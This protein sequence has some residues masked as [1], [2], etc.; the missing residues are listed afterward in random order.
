MKK[1]TFKKTIMFILLASLYFSLAQKVMADQQDKE[2]AVTA[3]NEVIK[4]DPNNAELWLHLGFAYRKINKIS[5]AQ[6]AFEKT[7]ELN[8]ENQEALF[9]L[10]LIYEK[11]KQTQKALKAWKQYLS[12]STDPEKRSLAEK[13]IHHLSQ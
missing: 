9:M 8:P 12:V 5:Q 3:L 13:H 7:A 6:Q 11:N 2:R 4:K 1:D 10:G